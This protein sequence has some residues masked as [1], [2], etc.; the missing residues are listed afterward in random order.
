MG[1]PPPAAG[2]PARS[3]FNDGLA[4]ALAP[5]GEKGAPEDDEALPERTPPPPLNWKEKLHFTLEDPAYSGLAKVLSIAMILVIFVSTL[6]FVLE[7]EVAS[8]PASPKGAY[9]MVVVARHARLP[10]PAL[11]SCA[12]GPHPP[13]PCT[14]SW[15]RTA[16][17]SAP[18]SG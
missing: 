18:S 16:W 6:S 5:E 17:Q 9:C 12:S 7:S 11:R 10:P 4:H 2:R 8:G 15:R 3:A 14:C 13:R 1:V